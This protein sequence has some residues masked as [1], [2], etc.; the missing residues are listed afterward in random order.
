MSRPRL[1]RTETVT[2]RSAR[3]FAKRSIAASDGRSNG[4]PGR[5]VQRNQVHLRFHAGQQLRQLARVFG[6]VVHAGEQHVLERDAAALASGNRLHASMISATP[7]FLLIGTSSPRCTSVGA[8]SEIARFGIIGSRASRSSAGSRPTVD[9]VTRR[10]GSAEPVLVGQDPQR[11]H[12]L[13]VVVQRLAHAHQDDVEGLVLQ[14]ERVCQHA[15]LADDF[16]SRQVAD[17]AHLARQAERAGHGAADL[18]RDAEGHGRR[19]GNEDRLDLSAVGEAQQKLLGAV[20]RRSRCDEAGVVS[21]KSA[22]SVARRSRDRSVIAVDVG[23]AAAVDPAEDLARAEAL[24][25]AR[26]ERRFERWAIE[27]GEI[28]SA[29]SRYLVSFNDLV[30]VRS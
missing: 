22:A 8:C 23:D 17:Q 9:S 14:V 27:L 25:S 28:E 24:V 6:R 1:L 10:G 7:Y 4:M 26:G 11:L 21:V 18:R 3:I 15:N 30:V 5:G 16:A 20:A 13:V 2:P 12:R 19:V 29:R